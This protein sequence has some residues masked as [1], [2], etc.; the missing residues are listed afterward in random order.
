MSLIRDPDKTTWLNEVVVALAAVGF[1]VLGRTMLDMIAPGTLPFALTFPAVIF[2]SLIA[3]TRS[4]A[5]AVIICQLLVW[6]FVFPPPGSFVLTS[7]Q[8]TSL[9]FSTFSL[10]LTV[11]LVGRYRAVQARLRQ[12]AKE[13]VDL[14]SLALR[15]VDHRTKN[16]FQI[17]ASLLQSQAAAQSDPALAQELRNAASRLTSIAGVYADLAL[18][19]AGLSTVVLHEYLRELCTRFSETMLPP[20]VSL[21]FESEPVEV[22]AQAA[23]TI[24]LIVNECLTNAAKHAFPRGLGEIAVLVRR[25]DQAILIEVRDDGVGVTGGEGAS[26]I[27]ST[28]IAT[29]AR[30]IRAS[31]A[32]GEDRGRIC[33]LRVPL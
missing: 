29:L 22:P 4:G 33:T 28:L 24:G 25:E 27:G 12:E 3:G 32:T 2:A 7:G 11:W 8:A 18:S 30:S 16:N 9:I 21:A 31:F 6:Y 1:A 5:A 26:G 13:R 23:T 17:A 19:S 20:T 10:G 14:L 15:E